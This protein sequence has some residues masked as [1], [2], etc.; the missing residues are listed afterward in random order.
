MNCED[1]VL[2]HGVGHSGTRLFAAMAAALGWNTGKVNGTHETKELNRLN[3]LILRGVGCGKAQKQFLASLPSP[4]A[5]KCTRTVVTLDKWLPLLKPY[6]PAMLYVTRHPD[7]MSKTHRRPIAA[8]RSLGHKVSE[9]CEIA[10]EQYDAWPWQKWHVTFEQVARWA[11]QWGGG[12][13]QK[14][15]R[16]VGEALPCLGDLQPAFECVNL[17]RAR[18]SLRAIQ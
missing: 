2:I 1:N 4:W 5:I 10:R 8:K 15:V 18:K 7:A 12:N 17:E 3:K 6:K 11:L 14:V 13:R 9:L 16:E